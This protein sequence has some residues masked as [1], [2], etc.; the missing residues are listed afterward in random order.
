MYG[1]PRVGMLLRNLGSFSDPPNLSSH[2]LSF[3][4]SCCCCLCARA[5]GMKVLSEAKTQRRPHG[6]RERA[7]YG[8]VGIP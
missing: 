8:G 7:R 2:L 3:L 4:R 5:G 6:A 1:V